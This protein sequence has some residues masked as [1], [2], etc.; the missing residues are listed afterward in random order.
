MLPQ[1]IAQLLPKGKL[2]SEVRTLI[3]FG[4]RS[5]GKQFFSS[6]SAA[7]LSAASCLFD[8]SREEAAATGDKMID[9]F[10][11]RCCFVQSSMS[12]A[13]GGRGSKST[14]A[15]LCIS[16]WRT[17]APGRRRR[18]RRK[19]SEREREGGGN[20]K[21]RSFFQLKPRDLDLDFFSLTLSLSSLL[22]LSLSP[23]PNKIT[24][25][26]EWRGIGVQ[27]SRGW[28]HYAIHRPEP[29]VSIRRSLFRVFFLRRRLFLFFLPSRGSGTQN[30]KL[31]S[32]FLL[33]SFLRHKKQIM[34]FRRPKDYQATQQPLAPAHNAQNVPAQ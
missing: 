14:S 19:R 30:K 27:Q 28:V 33:F 20:Q 15:L 9:F 12:P 16:S 11:R 17:I 25:Q 13:E 31:F 21:L 8:R 23:R 2:L 24:K 6:L 5:V 18:R 34:L 32:L 29:H 4:G 1:D 10:P 7:L 26:A 3:S 22:S